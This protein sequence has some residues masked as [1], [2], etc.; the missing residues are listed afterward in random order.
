MTT[1]HGHIE[2]I[3]IDTSKENIKLITKPHLSSSCSM[4]GFFVS[5]LGQLCRLFSISFLKGGV[6][7]LSTLNTLLDSLLLKLQLHSQHH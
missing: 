6:I 3:Q 5:S 1:E 2:D 4:L 7:H